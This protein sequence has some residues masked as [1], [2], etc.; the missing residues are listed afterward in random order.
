MAWAAD[1]E[2]L[3]QVSLTAPGSQ[4]IQ[5]IKAVRAA[6]GMGLR[7][8]KDLVDSKL[9]ARVKSGL[10]KEEA[11]ALARKLS[12]AGATVAIGP[13]GGAPTLAAPPSRPA[14]FSVRLESFG[15]SKIMC[16]KVVRQATGL[17]LKETK[18]LVESAPVVVKEGLTKDAAERL[19]RELT[20]AGA[21]AQVVP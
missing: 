15:T 7:E 21:V 20:D 11:D 3:F 18:D 19:A 14:T 16:I 1:G 6:T 8:A 10:S 13:E 2:P 12:E 9:P 17:G 5:L 4:K